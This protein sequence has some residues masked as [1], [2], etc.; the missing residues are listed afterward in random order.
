MLV[1]WLKRQL[2]AQENAHKSYKQDQGLQKNLRRALK[3]NVE[4]KQ[5]SII[6]ANIY[7]EL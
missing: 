3:K 1:R 7:V 2:A 6:C 5:N 4:M